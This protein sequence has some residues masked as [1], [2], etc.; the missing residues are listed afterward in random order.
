[1]N[2]GIYEDPI[3][4]HA[5]METLVSLHELGVHLHGISTEGLSE[6]DGLIAPRGGGN[7]VNWVIGHLVMSRND[8]L[9][10][11]GQEPLFAVSKFDRYRVGTAPLTDE[12]EA[13]RLQEL[14]EN[15]VALQVPL[16]KALTTATNEMLTKAVPNSPTGN[17]NETVGSIAVAI[18]FHEAYHLGQIALIRHSL[19][20]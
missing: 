4:R 15:F 1:M 7:C 9:P 20:A 12:T 16:V 14:N 17:P 3:T 18:A 5:A 11:L 2:V 19:S 10:L 6:A 8:E 13:I